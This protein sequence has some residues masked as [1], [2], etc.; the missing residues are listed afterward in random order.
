MPE[1]ARVVRT[2]LN[3]PQG[4]FLNLP[5]KYRGYVGGF[6]S[7]KTWVGCTGMLA[8]FYEHPKINSKFGTVEPPERALQPKLGRRPIRYTLPTAI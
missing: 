8:H 6:G 4:Q 2:P 3:V 1:H 5:H 7:G